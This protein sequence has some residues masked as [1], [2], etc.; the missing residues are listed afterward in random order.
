MLKRL[1]QCHG[2]WGMKITY[3]KKIRYRGTMIT[4]EEHLLEKLNEVLKKVG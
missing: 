4:K 2:A 1:N 3:N